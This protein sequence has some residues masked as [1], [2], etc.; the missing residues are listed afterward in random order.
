MD[1]LP[2]MKKNRVGYVDNQTTNYKGYV[3]FMIEIKLHKHAFKIC[4]IFGITAP[5]VLRQ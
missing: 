4:A 3:E 2:Q 1:I 5:M